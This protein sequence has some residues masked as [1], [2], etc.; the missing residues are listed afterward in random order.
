MSKRSLLTIIFISCICVKIIQCNELAPCYNQPA[1]LC[2]SQNKCQC[3]KTDEVS[4]FCCHVQSNE[5][6]L[7]HLECSGIEKL[8]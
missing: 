2:P 7:K 4:L 3:V 8:L 5:D 6:L 1:E